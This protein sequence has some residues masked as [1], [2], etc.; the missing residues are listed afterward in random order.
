M[1]AVAAV[2]IAIFGRV[3]LFLVQRLGIKFTIR[4]AVAAAW[5]AAVAV[6]NS[7]GVICSSSPLGARCA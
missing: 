1:N 6:C 3:A 7:G 5:L 4:M 2:L